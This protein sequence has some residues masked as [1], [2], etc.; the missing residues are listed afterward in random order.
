MYCHIKL[1]I[2]S[3][4]YVFE[5]CLGHYP[6]VFRTC[7]LSCVFCCFVVVLFCFS[8]GFVVVLGFFLPVCVC[9]CVCV[10]ARVCWGVGGGSCV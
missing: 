10:C 7:F 2:L 1:V 3:T 8:S 4:V 6:S 9:V 5:S